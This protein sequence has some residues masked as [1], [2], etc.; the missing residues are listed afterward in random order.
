MENDKPKL[1]FTIPKGH[2]W[3]TVSQLLNDAGYKVGDASRNYRPS[4]NDEQ[5]Q[6]KVL[7]PQEIPVY[8]AEGKFDLG[9]SGRDWVKETGADVTEI[10]DLGIGSVRLVFCI[11]T[12]CDEKIKSFD[13]FLQH[14][15]AQKKVLRI[16]TEY[17][18]TTIEF[19]MKSRVYQKAFGSK[20][21]KVCTPWQIWGDNEQV[22]IFLSFGA[23]EAKPP[24]EVDCIIDN[25]DT[26]TT[27]RENNLRI[28]ETIDSS[29]AVLFANPDALND[30]F[31]QEKIHDIKILLEGVLDGRK[32]LFVFMNC[33]REN[34]DEICGILP[35]LKRPTMSDLYG[36]PSWVA[37]NT[38][39]D[40]ADFLP[41]ITKLKKLAQGIVVVPPRQ[42]IKTV[43]EVIIEEEPV[44]SEE[45][46][47]PEE[48]Q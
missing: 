18:N 12:S 32:K 44:F 8:V 46:A 3:D 40:K 34:L 30:E 48:D 29:S 9:I 15:I 5:I 35:A 21:P 43:E 26:G 17:I 11:P 7:R 36:D 1:K 24:E 31:K 20:K 41:A 4:I 37:I 45:E 27:I 2:L 38:I 25:T 33:K 22:K 13:D 10:M 6:L 39:M 42:V 23:T 16:T 19:I 47:P 28:V 14:F